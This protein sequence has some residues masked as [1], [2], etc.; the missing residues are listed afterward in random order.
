MNPQLGVKNPRWQELRCVES[1]EA[2]GLPDGFSMDM[3]TFGGSDIHVSCQSSAAYRLGRLEKRFRR[4]GQSDFVVYLQTKGSVVQVQDGREIQL[5]QGDITS[6]DKTRPIA[7]K[8]KE[9]CEQVLVHIPRALVLTLFGPTERFTSRELGKATPLGRVVASFLRGLA[10]VI[11][12]LSSP[13]ANTVSTTAG[14]LVMAILAEHASVK[15][16]RH[17]WAEGAL[18]YRAEEFIRRHNLHSDLT[19]KTVASALNVSLR[20]LQAAFHSAHTTPSEYI[21]ECRLA[22]SEQDLTNSILKPLN[23]SEIA[24]RN[25][26]ADSAHFCRRFKERFGMSPREYRSW[27]SSSLGSL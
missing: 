20:S 6:Q 1:L 7:M 9:E 23:I 4:S 3:D 13:T 16:D 22:N 15:I 11:D 12:Q 26:F 24:S 17:N 5:Q 21:W 18:R 8:R 10:P 14:S 27:K 25:G 2:I 19:P